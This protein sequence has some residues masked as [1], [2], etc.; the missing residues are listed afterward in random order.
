MCGRYA[1][2]DVEALPKA[3][4]LKGISPHLVKP[5]YNAAPSQDMPVI[6]SQNGQNILKLMYWGF[7]PAWAKGKSRFSFSAFNAR[8]ESL[9]EKPMWRKVFP[10][11]RCLV[12]V[13]GFYEW[14]GQGADK[15]PYYIH[16][17]KDKFLALAGLYDELVD[18][19]SGEVFDSFTIITTD[20]NL[21][22]RPIHNRMPV[23]FNRDDQ[24]KWLDEQF[25]DESRLKSMLE[26][27]HN[28]DLEAYEVSGKVGNTRNNDASL[29]EPAQS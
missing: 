27:D 25:L 28:Y 13:S 10:S 29:L 4:K 2:V 26:P 3:F 17:K 15:K 24:D 22:M 14:Q 19:E 16:A 7:I 20:A 9:I 6:I 18:K 23:I 8:A 11:Q 1:L 12:P 21:L 5:N